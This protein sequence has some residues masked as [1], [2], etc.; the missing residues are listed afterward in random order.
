MAA[1]HVRALARSGAVAATIAGAI[2]CAAGWSWA[3]TLIGYFVATS[4]LSRVGARR[5]EA[6]V[7]GIVAK[8]GT[9]DWGQVAANGGIF[10]AGAVAWAAGWHAPEVAAFALGSLAAAAADSWATEIGTLIGGTPRSILTL[11]RVP[12]GTSG[13]VS[14]PGTAAMLAGAAFLGLLAWV[15]GWEARVAAAAAAGGVG[16]AVLDSL[17]GA[18]V[19]ARRWCPRCGAATERDV[20]DCG[21][22][23]TL[24]GGVRWVDND[25]VNVACAAGGALLAVLLVR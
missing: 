23:T 12:P 10:V 6:R 25:V 15:L 20:H 17:L 24:V 16:G 18:L 13:A 14:T 3:F 7:G 22:P 21:T 5:K 9:R 11:R 19:Q 8:G 4:G 2:A 1:W